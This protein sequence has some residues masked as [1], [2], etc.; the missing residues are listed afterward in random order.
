[1]GSPIRK[2]AGHRLFAPHRS[3]SQLVTSFVGSWCQGIHLALFL[4][5]PIKWVLCLGRICLNISGSSNLPCRSMTGSQNLSIIQFSRCYS[6]KLKAW[7]WRL[8]P[9]TLFEAFPKSHFQLLTSHPFWMHGHSKLNSVW[10]P[11]WNTQ[12]VDPSNK[13]HGTQSVLLAISSFNT[14]TRSTWDLPSPMGSTT[15]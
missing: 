5:W 11:R 3:L 9:G 6:W 15:P 4:A 10:G 1:V 8:E 13:I 14:I 2:S 7:C 12:P